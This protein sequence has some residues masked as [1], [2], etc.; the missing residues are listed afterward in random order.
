MDA[1]LNVNR[2]EV[3]TSLGGEEAVKRMDHDAR[4][5]A[6]EEFLSGRLDALVAA[7]KRGKEFPTVAEIADKV[8]TRSHRRGTGKL[9]THDRNIQNPEAGNTGKTVRKLAPMPERPTL[10]DFFKLRF[11]PAAHLLQ[12]ARLARKNGL[13]EEIIL[14]CLLH[15]AGQYLCRADHGYWGAQI[16]EPYVSERVVFAI[17]YHQAL[18]FYPD[19]SVNYEYPVSYYTTFGVD[20]EPLPHVKAAYEYA[21]NHKWYMDARMVTTNDLYAFDPNV[22]VE[23]EEFTNIVGRN[24][25]QPKE[26]LG[27]D[28]TPV[29]HMWRS[30]AMPDAP[31]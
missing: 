31:L 28:N 1:R 20:Y 27:N 13:S 2:E 14:A 18:R 3:L 19:P 15:D 23:I 5:D 4:A 30:M 7:R 25:R 21:R 26:G 24:F 6:L 12:S 16:V 17:K 10:I 29:S 11:P 8:D 22:H 9:F